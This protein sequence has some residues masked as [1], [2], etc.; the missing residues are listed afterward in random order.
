VRDP[1]QLHDGG[2]FNFTTVGAYPVWSCIAIAGNALVLWAV[3]V[4]SGAVE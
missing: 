3:T 2:R 4:H 1:L